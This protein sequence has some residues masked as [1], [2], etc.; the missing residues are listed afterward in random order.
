MTVKIIL[1]FLLANE[2]ICQVIGI[3][4]RLDIDSEFMKQIAST[5]V[6]LICIFLLFNSC[7]QQ[8]S[9][10]YTGG[11]VVPDSSIVGIWS[12]TKY[13]AMDKNNETINSTD[14]QSVIHL[15]YWQFGFFS[16]SMMYLWYGSSE[17]PVASVVFYYQDGDIYFGESG[18]A[19]VKSL[20]EDTLVF[21]SNSFMPIGWENEP[22]IKYVRTTCK[23]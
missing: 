19:T 8:D 1:T 22:N 12:V 14:D 5:S 9:Y 15:T 10:N 4:A 11:T 16:S 3:F 23:K 2:R 18:Y 21:D 13:E 7:D 6:F 17:S 20:T